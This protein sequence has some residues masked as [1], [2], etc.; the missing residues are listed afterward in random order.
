MSLLTITCKKKKKKSV[1]SAIFFQGAYLL[2][3]TISS[4]TTG[5]KMKLGL[6]VALS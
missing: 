2:S 1:S 4:T 6:Q 3:P 5:M